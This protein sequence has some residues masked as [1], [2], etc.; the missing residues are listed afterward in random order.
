MENAIRSHPHTHFPISVKYEGSFVNMCWAWHKS[1]GLTQTQ[2]FKHCNYEVKLF[3]NGFLVI[4]LKLFTHRNIKNWSVHLK[5]SHKLK[6]YLIIYQQKIQSEQ[7]KIPYWCEWTFPSV[8]PLKKTHLHHVLNN[9][10]NTQTHTHTQKTVNTETQ[11]Y[12]LCVKA[13]FFPLQQVQ[14]LIA[15]WQI[16]KWWHKKTEK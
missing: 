7:I 4:T 10:E 1:A 6:L 15:Y 12:E 14:S 3:W 5:Y 2:K 9:M 11:E 8:I 16:L 13:Q